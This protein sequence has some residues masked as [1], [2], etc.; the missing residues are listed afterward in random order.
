MQYGLISKRKGVDQFLSVIDEIKNEDIEVWFIGEVE[1]SY[2]TTF[3]NKIAKHSFIKYLGIKSFE[4]IMVLYAQVYCVVV[5]SLLI[6]NYPNTV[7]EAIA[8]RTLVIG[9]NR[10]GIP[11]LIKDNR[12]L[13]DILDL[14]SFKNSINTAL[15]TNAEQYKTVTEQSFSIIYNNNAPEMYYQ[16]LMEIYY[17]IIAKK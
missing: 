16:R 8:N 13:F 17:T 4:D 5:P 6:E 10:G 7:L 15:N 12:F 9:S 1:K 11:E 14:E 3:F 2:Q